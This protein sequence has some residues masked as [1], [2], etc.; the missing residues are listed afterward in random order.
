M[1]LPAPESRFRRAL[2]VAILLVAAF[3]LQTLVRPAPWIER[4]APDFILAAVAGL[5]MRRGASLGLGLGL[6][7]GLLQ[8]SFSGGLLGIHG[9]SKP[10]TAF[11]IGRIAAQAREL[12]GSLA[13]VLALVAAGLDAAVLLFLA[14]VTGAE[15][16]ARPLAVGLGLPLTAS[17]GWA[18]ARWLAPPAASTV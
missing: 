6:G 1:N 7:A 2:R 10:L 3:L 12:S 11:V 13:F 16:T 17:A 15:V 8:D 5:A 18:A 9:S 14:W 4:V